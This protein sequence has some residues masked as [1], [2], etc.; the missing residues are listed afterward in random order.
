MPLSVN[1]ARLVR[2]ALCLAIVLTVVACRHERPAAPP[3]AALADSGARYL[4]VADVCRRADLG[5]LTMLYPVVAQGGWDGDATGGSCLVALRSAEGSTEGVTVIISASIASS[6]AVAATAYTID[7]RDGCTAVAA[8]GTAATVCDGPT[9][10]GQLHVYDGNLYLRVGWSP[11]YTQGD[12]PDLT[13][14]LTL[15]TRDVLALLRAP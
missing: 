1:A 15:V 6:A 13:A 3:S 4:S 2:G 5:P 10:G 7:Q 8:L 14:E 12:A 9:A 11:A